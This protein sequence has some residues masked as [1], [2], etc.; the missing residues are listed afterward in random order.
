MI[1]QQKTDTFS[2][3]SMRARIATLENDLADKNSI[4]DKNNSVISKL[5]TDLEAA[6]FQVNQMQRMIFGCRR[7][8]FISVNDINQL[9]L[10][11]EPKATEIS[12]AVK[13]ERE[14]IRMAYERRKVKKEDHDRMQL[15]SNS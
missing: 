6:R 4:I 14:L 2:T 5:T 7:E 1:N 10:E 3:V 11:F 12:Q 8:R 13:P 15:P 9:R